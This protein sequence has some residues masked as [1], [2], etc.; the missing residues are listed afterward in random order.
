MINEAKANFDKVIVLVNATNPMEIANLKDDPDTYVIGDSVGVVSPLFRFYPKAGHVAN[1][2]MIGTP[3]RGVAGRLLR[4]EVIGEQ[5][6]PVRAKA[7]AGHAAAGEKFVEISHCL[8]LRL[9][10]AMTNRDAPG[11]PSRLR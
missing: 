9:A 6:L 1:A 11:A 5:T 7:G 3:I 4:V 2:Q 10:G 8:P